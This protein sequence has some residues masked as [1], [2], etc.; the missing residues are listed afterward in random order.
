MEKF[1]SPGRARPES[2]L[3]RL[4]AA[5][6][7]D[8]VLVGAGHAHVQI[9]R[10]WMMAPVDGVRLTL[11]V[12][13]PDAVYSG[14]VPGFV[15]G[16][17][18]ARELEIDAVP[19]A[20]RAGARLV[21]SA[22]SG[23][24][25]TARR[26]LVEGRPPIAYDVVSFDVGSSLRGLELPGVAEHA[27]ATRPI[28]RFVDAIDAFLPDPAGGGA[29]TV[30][31]VGGGAA[32]VEL[33]FT[34]HARMRGR[35]ALTLVTDSDTVLPGASAA[36]RRRA[37]R[38][39]LERGVRVLPN[40]RVEAVSAKGVSLEGGSVLPADRVV[41]ATGAA[42]TPLLPDLG[43]PLTGKGFLRIRDTLQVVD[44]DDVFAAG[45]CAVLDAHAWVPR[46]GVYAVRQ[47]PVLD[48]NLRARLSATALGTYRPQRDF[49]SLLTLGEGR[50]LGGKWGIAFEGRGVFRLKDWID[51]RFMARFQVLA[52]DGS[53]AV[54]FPTPESMGMEEMACGGCAAK[55]GAGGLARVL[56]RLGPATADPAVRVGLGAPDDAAA[57][58]TR[59]GDVLLATVD[60]FRAFC[61]DPWLVG[62]V[63][64]QNAVSDVDATGGTARHALAWVTVPDG[65]G[66]E[67]TLY[68]VMAGV[69]QE[70]DARRISLLGGHS[71]V[72]PELMVGLAVLGE[73]PPEH[74][75]LA[76]AGL[77]PGDRLILTKPLGTGVAL[78]AD[79]QGRLEGRFLRAVHAAMLRGNAAAAGI[80][81]AHGAHA[82]T[83]VSGFGLAVHLG[84]ML[85]AS[86]VGA[87][88]A[89]DRVPVL[90]GVS[91][92]LRRGVRSTF[93]PQNLAAARRYFGAV[94][95]ETPAVALLVDPQTSGGL[96]IG[97]DAGRAAALLEAL[98]AAGD[99]DAREI[100]EVVSG[101]AEGPRLALEAYAPLGAS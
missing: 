48:A 46:A 26:V 47:G 28:R 39:L 38:A 31:V 78:A 62:R 68:Q 24:D 58:A 82:M 37:E 61:D 9:L 32:G 71:T 101:T 25:P 29:P 17:Y 85:E 55:V 49:L 70:L 34:L 43:L 79:M 88:L 16:A 27:L 56:A 4:G 59:S 87:A 81:R 19:L 50:A 57:F 92:A 94:D 20:R 12:D 13:R 35:G 51:R 63:A 90:P 95:G 72:G 84:E 91:D 93:H 40:A 75:M 98:E 73:L 8:L 6:T 86:G 14:M 5:P 65:P 1:N 80:A 41:W 21:L 15:A 97:I 66:A 3:R 30:T 22:A 45:D 83:D 96:L 36:L 33:A 42:P 2:P 44:H 54:G 69:R 11:I 64:T 52:A 53:D 18:Q 99:T 23:L 76:K 89:P 77:K 67:E 60:G 100:G 74:A 10:R 7:R